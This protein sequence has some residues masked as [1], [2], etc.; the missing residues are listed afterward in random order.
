MVSLDKAILGAYFLGGVALGGSP[1]VPMISIVRFVT[2]MYFSITFCLMIR[3]CV[4][5]LLYAYFLVMELFF[6]F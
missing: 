3:L 5:V 6:I 4:L 2:I 1:S